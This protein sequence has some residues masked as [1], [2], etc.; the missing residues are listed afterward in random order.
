M[1]R[2]LGQIGAA[3]IPLS[4]LFVNRRNLAA[5]EFAV[6]VEQRPTKN[7]SNKN[8]LCDCMGLLATAVETMHGMEL[9]KRLLRSMS[10]HRGSRRK[11][12]GKAMQIEAINDTNSLRADRKEKSHWKSCSNLK[13]TGVQCIYVF[14]REKGRTSG[15]R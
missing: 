14:L 5:V 11:D 3:V 15:Y 13:L 9:L 1:L 8:A 10:F 7:K 6:T 2:R 12:E 4:Y